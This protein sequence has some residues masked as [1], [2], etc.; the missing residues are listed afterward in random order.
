MGI[1]ETS[2]EL[3]SDC[4]S[5]LTCDLLEPVFNVQWDLS[6]LKFAG[7]SFNYTETVNSLSTKLV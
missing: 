4:V 5:E 3:M 2:A 6:N 7:I 1:E